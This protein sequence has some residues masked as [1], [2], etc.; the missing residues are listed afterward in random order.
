LKEGIVLKFDSLAIVFNPFT[1][2]FFTILTGLLFGKIRFGKFSFDTSGALFT[3]LAIGWFVLR[4]ANGIVAAGE[5]AAGY[6]AAL[7]AVNNGVISSSFLDASLIFFG[8]SVG[9]LAAKDIGTVV[10]KYGPKFIVLGLLITFIGGGMTY[11]ATA[12]MNDTNPYEVSGVF[13]GSLT[14][15]PGLGA[16]LETTRAH[17]E[18]YAGDY[19]AQSEGI[20]KKILITIDSSGKLT[21]ENTPSLSEDQKKTYIENAVASVGV[22]HAIA[23]PFG[24]II[25]IFTV[26]FF[27]MIFRMDVEAEKLRYDEEMQHAKELKEEK[28]IKDIPASAFSIISFSIVCVIGYLIGSIEI[29]MGPLGM[30]SLGATGGILIMG[31]VLG[32]IGRIG[33][34]SFR[35]DPKVLSVI[36]ELGLAFFLAIV[37]LKYGFRA[38]DALTGSGIWLALASLVVGVVAMLIGFLVGKYVFKLNWVLMSGAICGGM[39][40]TPGLGAAIKALKSDNPAAGYGATYPFA[41]FGMIV[42]TIVLD[43]LP[44]LA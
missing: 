39:T 9:L 18:E 17:T 12:I 8:A 28:G 40:S 41:L 22:G 26:T 16:A 27:P 13:H 20:K 2:M 37:G 7:T 30:F 19:A 1:L 14:S 6:K 4:A 38:L 36:R 29:F 31:L 23:Y 25:V 3:G 44:L 15:S 34:I 42:F 11:G 21:P 5:G 43:K 10:R 35:L 24:V 33:P 32:A